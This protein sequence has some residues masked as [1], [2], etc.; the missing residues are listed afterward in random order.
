VF[1]FE[2]HS[3]QL[4]RVA[5][6]EST[7]LTREKALAVD[8]R[9]TGTLEVSNRQLAAGADKCGVSARHAAG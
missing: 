6:L 2:L 7:R 9:A 8:E 4:D 1:D 5:W 3:T